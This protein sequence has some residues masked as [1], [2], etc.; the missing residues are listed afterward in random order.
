MEI[1]ILN[2]IRVLLADDHPSVLERLVKLLSGDYEIVGTVNN[3][4][5]A[6]DDAAELEPDVLVLDISMPVLGGIETAERLQDSG[7]GA[8]IVFLTVHEDPDFVQAAL[9]TGAMG[10]VTKARL[11]ADLPGAL[12]DAV[13]GRLFVSETVAPGKLELGS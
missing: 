6:L 12:E 9:A 4:Q 5:A 1:R 13:A 8:K 11:A 7:C 2:R 3:G 10:Y